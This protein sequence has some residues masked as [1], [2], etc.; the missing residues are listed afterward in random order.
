MR[1]TGFR[2][3]VKAGWLRFNRVPYCGVSSQLLMH[4][5][6]IGARPLGDLAE[7][8]SGTNHVVDRLASTLTACGWQKHKADWNQ[9]RD[10]VLRDIQ[11]H[12]MGQAECARDIR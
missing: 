10:D 12:V 3:V 8:L 4:L 2:Y 1:W 7:M 5:A 11:V 6:R 9:V